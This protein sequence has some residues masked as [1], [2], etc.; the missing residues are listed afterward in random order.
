MIEK[1]EQHQHYDY[2]ELKAW[3]A[4]AR[5]GAAAYLARKVKEHRNGGLCGPDIQDSLGDMR[6]FPKSY[7]DEP[8]TVDDLEWLRAEIGNTPS[9]HYWW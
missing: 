9:I 5:P 6:E 8:Y 4:E 7:E 3:L 1:P 2:H